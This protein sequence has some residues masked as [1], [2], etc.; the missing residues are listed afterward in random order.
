M[1]KKL[2]FVYNS[3]SGL[4]NSVIHL[5]HKKFSPSTYDCQLC[6]LVYDGVGM[7][8][9]WAAFI[10]SLNIETEFLHRNTFV[11]RYG[12]T[13]EALP[14]VLFHENGSNR[15]VITAADFQ[16]IRTLEAL[17]YEVRNAL[18]VGAGPKT[19]VEASLQRASDPA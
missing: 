11:Q 10:K 7:D 18:P 13:A 2:I 3:D 8:K 16:S 1:S 17:V 6:M 12:S 14:V 15:P 9:D 4:V 5:L 19:T